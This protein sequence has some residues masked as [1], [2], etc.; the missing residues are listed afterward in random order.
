MKAIDTYGKIDALVNDAGINADR[1]AY[2]SR[3]PVKSSGMLD[4]SN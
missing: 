3:P 2:S 4:L 1:A